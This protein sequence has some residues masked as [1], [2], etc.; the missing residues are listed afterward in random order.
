MCECVCASVISILVLSGFVNWLTPL[1][2]LLAQMH[3]YGQIALFNAAL[4][5]GASVFA[6]E[7]NTEYYFIDMQ[8]CVCWKE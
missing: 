8:A 6:R 5:G 2:D 4:N 7:R 1:E 3:R